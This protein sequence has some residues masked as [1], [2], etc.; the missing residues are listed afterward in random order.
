MSSGFSI[1]WRFAVSVSFLIAIGWWLDGQ[2]IVE[3]LLKLEARWLVVALVLSCFQVVMSAWRWRFIARRLGLELALSTAIREYYLAVFINQLVPGGVVGDVSRAWR[4]A[5]TEET[6][7]VVRAV[8]LER[9]SGQFIM[10][11]VA[12]C[13]CFV[14]RESLQLEA[15]II[16]ILAAIISV[17]AL[18]FSLWVRRRVRSDRTLVDNL[19]RDTWTALLA[20]DAFLVQLV[21]SALIVSSYLAMFLIAARAL[22]S[23]TA[24]STLLPLIAPVLIA[25]LI[26]VSIA[27]WGLREGAAALLWTAAGLAAAD[28]AAI[29]AAYGL[30]VVFSSVPGGFVLISLIRAKG[31]LARHHH[32]VGD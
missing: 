10:I 22:G 28:G 23:T 21:T 2:A 18:A 19:L 30:L 27:G 7:P 11:G 12:I 8:I 13:S 25:M 17:V 4:H 24:L 6:G 32:V 29:S 20:R 15:S 14:L 16:W 9:A 31:I 26:P 5:Q 3:R 1:C